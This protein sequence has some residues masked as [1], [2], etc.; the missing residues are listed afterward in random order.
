[1]LS[2]R[3]LP[4]E[5]HLYFSSNAMI[6][7]LAEFVLIAISFTAIG[8]SSSLNANTRNLGSEANRVFTN[9]W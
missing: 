7:R 5:K 1:M 6:M 9:S 3:T 4:G 8:I 2:S